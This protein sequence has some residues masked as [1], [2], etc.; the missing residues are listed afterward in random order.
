[1]KNTF[2]AVHANEIPLGHIPVNELPPTSVIQTHDLL[3]LQLQG[4]ELR[5][6]LL[7]K[8][9]L[10]EGLTESS[11]DYS[12][13]AIRTSALKYAAEILPRDVSEVLEIDH[14]IRDSVAVHTP[15]T[16]ESVTLLSHAWDLVR[17]EE[18]KQNEKERQDNKKIAGALGASID[19]LNDKVLRDK[20]GDALS[21]AVRSNTS[22]LAEYSALER[23]LDSHSDPDD[24]PAHTI[25]DIPVPYYD[26]SQ[27][28][29]DPTIPNQGTRLVERE[30]LMIMPEEDR[31][32]HILRLA[33][34]TL[35]STGRDANIAEDGTVA[36]DMSD[37]LE[38]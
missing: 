20:F 3:R 23:S 30:S 1:M 35:R 38:D 37:Y 19:F 22:V 6:Q 28:S 10:P 16:V 12:A 2:E 5:E 29:Y 9:S 31:H 7:T 4:P 13:A 18:E 24:A 26:L 36:V 11:I 25:D 32:R 15:P 34:A 33:E 21:Q 8:P 17:D 14:D 27:P